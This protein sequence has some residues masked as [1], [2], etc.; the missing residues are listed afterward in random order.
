MMKIYFFGENQKRASRLPPPKTIVVFFFYDIEL[1]ICLFA[2]YVFI[3][4]RSDYVESF[5]KIFLAVTCVFAPRWNRS[6]LT[7]LN[8]AVSRIW[9]L[10]RLISH[11]SVSLCIHKISDNFICYFWWWLSRC[12]YLLW[13]NLKGS[14]GIIFMF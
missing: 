12:V 2:K 14:G 8:R 1:V 10:C 9:N 6:N 4:L 13:L 7:W 5:S 3:L 11:I